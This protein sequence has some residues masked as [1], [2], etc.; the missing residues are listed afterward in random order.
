MTTG[1]FKLEFNTY[2]NNITSNQAPGVNDYEISQFLT[3]AQE[4]IVS[5]LYESINAGFEKTESVRRSLNALVK[6]VTYYIGSKDTDDIFG[7]N[8]YKSPLDSAD[9]VMRIVMEWAKIEKL[10]PGQEA[11]VRTIEVIPI[12][13]DDFLRTYK[14]PFRGITKDR[15]IR[16]DYSGE[17]VPAG[18]KI[19]VDK[20]YDLTEYRVKYLKKPEPIIIGNNEFSGLTIDGFPATTSNECQLDSSVHRSILLRAVQL[21]KAAWQSK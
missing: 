11:I 13:Y 21:A 10:V 4:Q 1:E 3:L 17:N 12:K 18:S 19:Y 16:V 20:D 7:Y 8:A 2:Y 14:N 5:E 9:K 6:E 15:A